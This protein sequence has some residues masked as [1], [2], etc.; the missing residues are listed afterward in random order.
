MHI[1]MYK[2]LIT[3]EAEHREKVNIF[4]WLTLKNYAYK[5]LVKQLFVGLRQNNM[6]SYTGIGD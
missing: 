6:V 5:T 4:L 3:W 1:A 2:P